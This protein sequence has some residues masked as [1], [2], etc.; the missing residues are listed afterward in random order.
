MDYIAHNE[1]MKKMIQKKRSRKRCPIQ[2]GQ[3]DDYAQ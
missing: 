3:S 2:L 1:N